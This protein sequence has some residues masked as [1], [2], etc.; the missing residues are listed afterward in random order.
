MLIG[1]FAL[2]SVPLSFVHYYYTLERVT[3]ENLAASKAVELD[4]KAIDFSSREQE[5]PV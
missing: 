1:G 4:E 5:K 3:L 2:L